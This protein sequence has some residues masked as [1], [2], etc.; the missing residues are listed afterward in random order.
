M[1]YDATGHID[2]WAKFLDDRTVMVNE[3]RPEIFNL[4]YS[5]TDRQKVQEIADYLD[6]RT[7]EM[8]RLGFRVVRVPMP[9]P[10]FSN[11]RGDLIRSY[12]NSLFVNGATIVPVYR[13]P[14]Y[15]AE[16]GNRFGQYEDAALLAEYEAEA[17][18]I[19]RQYGYRTSTIVTD[20]LIAMFGAVH[21][22]TMQI[23]Q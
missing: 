12:T 9:A 3:I 5:F 20:D 17:L 14:Y 7:S 13:S 11:Q 19:Y 10:A 21:C 16:H 18:N 15:G 2:M 8:Q 23:P 4:P 22:V 6:A 1:P